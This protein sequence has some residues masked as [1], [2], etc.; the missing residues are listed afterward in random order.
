MGEYKQGLKH[1]IG[2]YTWPDLSTYDGSWVEGK[3]SG[4]GLYKWMDGRSY[5]GI[6]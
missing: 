5:E 2:K 4:F 3:I 1:G 6:D